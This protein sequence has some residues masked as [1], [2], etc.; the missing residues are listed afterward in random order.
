MDDTNNNAAGR[1]GKLL[2]RRPW[3]KQASRESF[4][5]A[6]SIDEQPRGRSPHSRELSSS[7]TKTSADHDG[8]EP[9]RRGSQSQPRADW[10]D[11][12]DDDDASP[13]PYSDVNETE[14]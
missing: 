6:I 10:Q 2:A 11:A 1:V 13:A 9:Q 4:G 7:S 3:K 12:P 8:D 5:S 14:S